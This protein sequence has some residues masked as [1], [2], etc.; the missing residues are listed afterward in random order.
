[1]LRKFYSTPK[2]SHTQIPLNNLSRQ[3]TE[4]SNGT[5]PGQSDHMQDFI[6]VE[7]QRPYKILEV[8]IMLLSSL[9]CI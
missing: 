8:T 7:M 5:S 4:T 1:M 2:E 9:D 6:S 3:G